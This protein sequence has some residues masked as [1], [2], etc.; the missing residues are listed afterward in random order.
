[1][2]GDL[3]DGPAQTVPAIPAGP[4]LPDGPVTR[5]GGGKARGARGRRRL[6]GLG[7]IVVALAIWEFVSVSGLVA[8]SILPTV[9]SVAS[10]IGHNAGRLSGSV[11]STLAAWAVGVAIAAVLGVVLGTAVGLWAAADAFTD[12]IV[13]MMR[14][15]PSLALIPI[16][17]LVAGLGLKMTA[18][19]VAFSAFWPVFI[20]TR[21]GV[22]QVE[23]AVIDAGRSL[24][25][26]GMRLVGRVILPAASPMIATGIQVAIGLAIVVTIS[27]EMVSGSGG[28]GEFVLVAQQGGDTPTM[29]AGIVAGGALGWALNTIFSAAMQW[30]LPW[31]H[32]EGQ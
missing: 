26:R 30:A 16:A 28:L 4:G 12:G 25:L 11:G 10:S 14:P 15:M 3:A 19:L 22:G 9:S 21:H 20:N 8:A 7:G 18:G 6:Y 1:M 24:D 23:N 27:V 29:Y 17:I 13:R 5:P 2:T 31:R 32:R